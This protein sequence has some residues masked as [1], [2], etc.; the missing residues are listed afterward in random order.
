MGLVTRQATLWG[1]GHVVCHSS[2]VYTNPFWA[3]GLVLLVRL[4]H[5]APPWPSGEGVWAPVHLLG[6]D[7][8]H[9]A[10]VLRMCTCCT[11][12][13]AWTKGDLTPHSAELILL[14]MY[15][16]RQGVC[17]GCTGLTAGMACHT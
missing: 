10:S 6:A 1:R 14:A 3:K 2:M 16:R 15:L 9:H 12:K 13:W 8:T 4:A 17:W 5:G 7:Y 11:R